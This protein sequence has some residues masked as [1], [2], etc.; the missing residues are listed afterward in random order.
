MKNGLDIERGGATYNWVMP[1]FVGMANLVD[2]LYAIKRLVFDEKRLTLGEFKTIL[3]ENFENNEALRSYIQNRIPK[4]GNDVDE[5]DNYVSLVSK[6]IVAECKQ[7]QGVH[8]NADLIPSVFCWVMHEQFGRETSATPDGRRTGFPLGDGSGPCQGRELNGP[9]AS[10]LSSTKWDHADFIGGVAVNLK[11]S[12]SSLGP[13]S[14]NTVCSLVEVFLNRGG[15][16][17]QINVLNNETLKKAQQNP[18]AYRDLLV[19]I[20]GYSDYF[21]KL[22]PQMQEEIILRT[23]HD[24]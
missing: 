15:F 12:K 13:D 4:Y 10:I 8:Q 3:D 17:V 22:T 2:S 11:F 6:R 23:A 18:D 24:L 9:T 1:S 20:G 19:R 7:Y 5:I 21:V 16:E 14:L